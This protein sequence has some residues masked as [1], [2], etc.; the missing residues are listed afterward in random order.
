MIDR[1][2]LRLHQSSGVVRTI[3]RV[4]WFRCI[5]FKTRLHQIC[6]FGNSTPQSSVTNGGTTVKLAR[7][8]AHLIVSGRLATSVQ[9]RQLFGIDQR[10][11]V[12]GCGLGD[13]AE[14]L[15]SLGFQV[16]AFD[17]SPTC[18]AWCRQRFPES[19][20]GYLVAD[21]FAPPAE[22]NGAFA[23]VLEAYTL[24]VLTPQLRQEAIK[25]IADFVAPDGRLLVITRGRD[26]SDGSGQMPWPLLYSELAQFVEYG[27]SEVQLD[28]YV[29][30]EEPPVRRF[31]VEYVGP[32]G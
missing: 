3:V 5:C 15:S 1:T 31:R 14:A 12:V 30:A 4:P 27:L 11:L 28:D 16:T 26:G 18:I 19:S 8:S 21:L 2:C 20:V 25:T 10:A 29:D 7:P 13:D 6:S 32:K 9:V 17:I 24:Q 22:W 23:F